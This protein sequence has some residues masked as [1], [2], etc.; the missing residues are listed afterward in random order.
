MHQRDVVE[1]VVISYGYNKVTPEPLKLKTVGSST[2]KEKISDKVAECMIKLGFQE[3]LSYMLTNKNNLFGRMN[4]NEEKI[5]EIENVVSENW[6]VFRNWLLPSLME[7]LSN[8]LHIEYPQKIFEIGDVVLLDESKETKT[9]DVRKISV[10]IA[11]S[12]IGYPDVSSIIDALLSSLGMK[13]KLVA[14]NHPSF[15]S[16]R[17]AEI[18]VNKKSIGFV[19]ELHPNVL[20]NWKIEMPVVAFEINIEELLTY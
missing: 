4:M 16:G 13:Y 14:K 15:I 18:I 5:A 19:G 20:A 1:D 7:F 9:R 12:R 6:C 11:D 17:A 10:A 8:N 3:I 2:Q